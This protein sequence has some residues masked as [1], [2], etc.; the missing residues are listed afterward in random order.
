VVSE[1][2]LL[3]VKQLDFVHEEIKSDSS[4]SLMNI[5]DRLKLSN[6]LSSELCGVYKKKGC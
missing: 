2:S 4:T 5:K 6:W 3:P 1:A